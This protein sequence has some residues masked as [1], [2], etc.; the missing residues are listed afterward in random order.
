MKNIT[1]ESCPSDTIV[2]PWIID[3]IAKGRDDLLVVYPNEAT[4]LS[5]IQ[6]ILSKSGH[7]DSSRHT[8]LQRLVKALSIDLRLPVIIPSTAT[9]L[10]QVHDKFADAARNHRFP[11]LHPDVARPWTLSKSERLLRLHAYVTK[12]RILSKWKDD[13]GALEA[14]RIV[15]T[16]ETNGLL[17]EHKVI[18]YLCDALSDQQRAIP[19]TCLLY[20]SPSPRDPM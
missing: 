16:F 7:V 2:P 11:R 4:R 19:Y 12:N 9:G 15:S 13:P 5:S 6:S 1:V 17:H 18:A 8:T 14:E 10:I 20:T 3:S